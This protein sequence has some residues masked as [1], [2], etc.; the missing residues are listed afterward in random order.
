MLFLSSLAAGWADNW[1]VLR[2]LEQ[3]IAT[4]RGLCAALGRGRMARAARWLRENVSGLA[5]NVSLGLL[6]GMT[7]ALGHAFGLPLDLRP[8]TLSAG[9]LAASTSASASALYRARPSGGP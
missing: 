4:S 6:R 8:V 2:D 1:F 7:P 3:G 9:F 5:G